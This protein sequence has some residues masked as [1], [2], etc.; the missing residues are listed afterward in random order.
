MRVR[1]TLHGTPSCTRRS[2]TKESLPTPGEPATTAVPAQPSN[3]TG[4]ASSSSITIVQGAPG[5]SENRS[6]RLESEYRTESSRLSVNSERES[7]A[8]LTPMT[9]LS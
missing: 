3:T 5:Y 4:A 6:G 7:L 1:L 9:P 8:I 2:R